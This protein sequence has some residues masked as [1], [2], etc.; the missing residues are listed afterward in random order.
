MANSVFEDAVSVKVVYDEP[1]KACDFA[2]FQDVVESRRSVRVFTADPIPAEVLQKCLDLALLA[3]NSSNLQTWHFYVVKN[4]ERRKALVT[5]CMS[6]PAAATA[7]EL[8][9]VTA[10]TTAW[11][12]NAK[13]MAAGLRKVKGPPAVLAYY[14]KLIPFVYTVGPCGILAPFRWLLFAVTGLFRPVPRG[15]YGVKD[16]EIGVHKSAAL[17]CE[18]LMLA[19][20]AAG[21]DSC[22][23]EGF[24]ARRVAKALSLPHHEKVCM[25][26]GAGRRKSDA[27][28]GPRFR[29]DRSQVITEC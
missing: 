19:L 7:A 1:A 26:I 5:A 29:F 10:S 17:G 3:P 23:M 13:T 14:E 2:A 11:K 27:I 20:R 12:K 9:V 4:P 22:P 6:Q 8:I 15:P 25:V 18:N 21:F 24:D 16:I 28:Y